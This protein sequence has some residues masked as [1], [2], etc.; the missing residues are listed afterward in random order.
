MPSAA[1]GESAKELGVKMP[2]GNLYSSDTFYDAAQ[3]NMRFARMGVMAVEMEAAA[4]CTAY[5]LAGDGVRVVFDA[6]QRAITAGQSVV[7]YDGDEV[8]G[9]GVIDGAE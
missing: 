4:P 1:A 7:L 9:G 8:L 6:P 5:P 2:V 3:R